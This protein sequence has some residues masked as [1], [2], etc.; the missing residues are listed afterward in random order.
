VLRALRGPLTPWTAFE[1]FSRFAARRRE[2]DPSYRS[3]ATGL[4]ALIRRG[5][6]GR[7]S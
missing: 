1:A 6:A 2:L 3:D 5:T 4:E 7:T